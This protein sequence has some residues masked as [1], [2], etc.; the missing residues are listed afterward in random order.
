MAATCAGSAVSDPVVI[1]S[2]LRRATSDGC[3]GDDVRWIKDRGLCTSELRQSGKVPWVRQIGLRLCNNRARLDVKIRTLKR[4]VSGHSD[5]RAVGLV[6]SRCFLGSD[7]T[8]TRRLPSS[9]RQVSKG[10]GRVQKSASTAR[11]A[12]LGRALVGTR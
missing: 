4:S 11:L 6:L 5:D 7:V 12:C 9:D 8:A 1:S 2:G 3:G 10:K